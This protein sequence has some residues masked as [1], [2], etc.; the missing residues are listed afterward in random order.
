MK[1]LLLL[2]PFGRCG[3]L[4]YTVVL[5]CAVLLFGVWYLSFIFTAP[6]QF[7]LLTPNRLKMLLFFRDVPNSLEIVQLVAA[8]VVSWLI[9]NVSLK[10]LKSLRQS[11]W[12]SLVIL[13]PIFVLI[14]LVKLLAIQISLLWLLL[15]LIFICVPL[16]VLREATSLELVRRHRWGANGFIR[17]FLFSEFADRKHFWKVFCGVLLAALVLIILPIK[18]FAV[19][20]KG[21][22]FIVAMLAI[23][24][25]LVYL[26]VVVTVQRLRELGQNGY[27]MLM[28]LPP[29]F[30]LLL[31][32]LGLFPGVA[33]LSADS[34][35]RGSSR[36][37]SGNNGGG[38][39]PVAQRREP[40]FDLPGD[41]PDHN[42][43][44][45]QQRNNQE[46]PSAAGEQP[47]VNDPHK[48]VRNFA[49]R[50]KKRPDG[51]DEDTIKI[52][53]LDSLRPSHEDL[54]QTGYNQ[55]V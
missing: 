27:I 35:P 21:G 31:W 13:L 19:M 26:M 22:I 9:F 49:I 37:Q 10:R 43:H 46:A 25:F 52:L 50:R 6:E 4:A 30:L 2:I 28:S 34:A 48:R 12:W 20:D 39:T 3:R 47:A 42:P 14:P 24:L 54:E 55:P 7:K 33:T 11:R 38:R 1:A 15:P 29:L 36:R 40:T 18:L 16:M 17:V 51:T 44:L 32:P 45:N 41:E 53:G 8:A 23:S 5:F